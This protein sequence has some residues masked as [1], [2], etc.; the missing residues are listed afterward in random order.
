MMSFIS[1]LEIPASEDILPCPKASIKKIHDP[2]D[3]TAVTPKPAQ[4]WTVEQKTVLFILKQHYELSWTDVKIL[5]R[6]LFRSE[7]SSPVGPSTAAIRSM[8]HGI[9]EKG[10]ASTGPWILIREAIE[11][12]A[13]QLGIELGLKDA[14][15]NDLSDSLLDNELVSG[16]ESDSTLLGDEYS[17][18][19]TPSKFSR[20]RPIRG[21]LE[22]G[23]P[24]SSSLQDGHASGREIP[25]IGFRTL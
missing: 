4:R 10:Y 24:K 23:R 14:R 7:L 15:F 18:P 19:L 11:R 1:H 9:K 3:Y 5:L 20:N 21:V 25:R 13:L 17:L 12:K 8:Y 6:E 2:S 22:I 16:D